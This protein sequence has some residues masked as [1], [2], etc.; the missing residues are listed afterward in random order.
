MEEEDL[1][2]KRELKLQWS[3]GAGASLHAGVHRG[4][5][6]R[7]AQWK[8]E[9]KRQQLAVEGEKSYRITD[10][11]KSQKELGISIRNTRDSETG[12]LQSRHQTRQKRSK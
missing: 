12:N 6:G 10:M 8:R 2:E 5:V 4:P 7:T 11:W 1:K 9:K 3:E